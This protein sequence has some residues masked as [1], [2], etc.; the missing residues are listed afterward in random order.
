MRTTIPGLPCVLTAWL[1]CGAPLAAQQATTPA[2]QPAR[3][4][5][6][7]A[8]GTVGFALG[9][10]A[11]LF[12]GAGIAYVV[13]GRGGDISDSR[14]LM[15]MPWT[16][17][18]V[19][20]G[21]GAGASAWLASRI[22]DQSSSLAWDIGAATAATVLAFKW[23]DWPMRTG[24]PRRKMSRFRRMAPV[25]GSA[26]AAAVAASVTRESRTPQR[27]TAMPY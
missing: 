12:T 18:V 2:L 22:D 14:G 23:A 7:L 11:G 3:I 20:G 15:R 27:S 1:V 19:G 10:H 21:A 25:W 8:A 6:E 9:T 17:I 24:K 13:R 5:G 26:L 16:M 4:V